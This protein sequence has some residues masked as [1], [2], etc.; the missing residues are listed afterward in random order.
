VKNGITSYSK[1]LFFRIFL[2]LLLGIFKNIFYV[3]FT[4]LTLHWSYL[5]FKL[6][7]PEA[8]LVGGKLATMMDTFIFVPACTAASAYLL[9]ALLILLTKGIPAM[10]RIEMFIY[11]SA[12]ILAFNLIR[13]EVLLL[14]FFRMDYAYPV[15]HLFFWKFLS[16]I[17][18]FAVWIALV[19]LFNVKSIPVYSDL[20]YIIGKM[21]R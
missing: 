14:F 2:A 20:K 9:L 5:F 13:I 10:K 4:P 17:F 8:V 16:T 18:V 15:V 7:V 19:R 1:S 6:S 21:K 11:G 12:A 3:I